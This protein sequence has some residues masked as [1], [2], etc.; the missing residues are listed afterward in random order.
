VKLGH[1][2]ACAA[3]EHF[4]EFTGGLVSGRY[5]RDMFCPEECRQRHADIITRW[6]IDAENAAAALLRGGGLWRAV[7]RA[8]F[9]IL[10]AAGCGV[11]CREDVRRASWTPMQ[12]QMV[13]F[14][15]HATA[16][17]RCLLLWVQ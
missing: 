9:F 17:V 11:E 14:C 12:Q 5:T 7:L 3:D 10:L 15:R 4:P 1:Y 13:A 2:A 6:G 16:A 8:A